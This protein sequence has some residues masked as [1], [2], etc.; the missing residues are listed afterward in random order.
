MGGLCRPLVALL[1]ALAVCVSAEPHQCNKLRE[2]ISC[3]CEA[4]VFKG[5]VIENQVVINCR[6]IQLNAVP[7]ITGRSNET[8]YELTLVHNNIQT[9]PAGAF[10][11]LRIQ[12]LDLR[13]NRLTSFSN[14]SFQGL[15]NDLKELYIGAENGASVAPPTSSLT[16]LTALN[17]LHLEYFAFQQ[18]QVSLGVL[19]V[20]T[21]LTTLTLKN[22]Q[23]SFIAP[24]ALPVYLTTLTL[25]NQAL[26]SFPVDVIRTLDKLESL[27]VT[28]TLISGL[29]RDSL[30]KNTKLIYLDLSDNKIAT[31]QE[32]CFEGITASLQTLSLK[33]NPL[34]TVVSLNE[35]E[36]LT[37]L[38]NLYLS[39]IG[40][41]T[42]PAGANFLLGKPSLIV[43][44]LD[45]NALTTLGADI[46]DSLG[47]LEELNLAYNQFTSLDDSAF[48]GLSSLKTLDL[49][50]QSRSGQGLT[51]PT[52]LTTLPSL[53][54]LQLSK[55]ILDLTV[56]WSRIGLMD[57]LQFLL[58]DGTSLTTIP[59][60]ALKN[61]TSL[62]ELNLNNNGLTEITQ[63]MLA[64]LRNL[65][66]LAVNKNSITTVSNC[67]FYDFYFSSPLSLELF[68]NPLVCDCKLK[69]LLD[70][71]QKGQITLTNFETCSSPPDKSGQLL[72]DLDS[73]TLT[74]V[75][76]Q[77]ADTCLELYTT[78]P[79]PSLNLA[80]TITNVNTTSL[81]LS[82]SL[83]DVPV[84]SHFQV[85]HLN[86]ETSQSQPVLSN[87]INVGNRS[88]QVTGL[89][90]NTPYSVCVFAFLSSTNKEEAC[91]TIR[92]L[93]GDGS[94]EDLGGGDN[95]S[96]EVGIIVGTV[97]GVLI[98]LVIIAAILYLLC[99][100]KRHS[101]EIPAQPHVFK[102]SELPTMNANSRQFTKPP[103]KVGRA[104]DEN[105]KVTV[106]SDGQTGPASPRH[107]VGSYQ[108]LND[109]HPNPN[110]GLG[111]NYSNNVDTRPLPSAP[112]GSWTANDNGGLH[113][114][115]SYD[116][117]ENK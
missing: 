34:Q 9:I 42:L 24:N 28:N 52:S 113:P 89:K 112:Q 103:P 91:N 36:R 58:L 98:L 6:N 59:D 10:K 25:D 102:P 8:I 31:L 57:S 70:E 62:K 110:P 47:S 93:A 49:G 50:H 100:R 77:P 86:L 76:A 38:T 35:I 111:P 11:G 13:K 109:K 41:S 21:R 94:A 4:R 15:E 84:V 82:W 5:V 14:S 1:C 90:P 97:V 71:H 29:Y 67:A 116:E 63:V 117:I 40:L 101:K 105:I 20:L 80:L 69:W 22:N 43:L 85:Q 115:H 106:I 23:L 3:P 64:G 87:D 39:S 30:L 66:N 2:I 44:H 107:S 54:T 56:L 12:R 37:A 46:F 27:T 74:C 73:G 45:G 79:A 78:T 53:Q 48:S 61:L 114:S 65:K 81:T 7:Q 95:S 26:T 88:F 51:L 104:L 60:Y 19:N 83:S 96:P 68:G 55:T 18:N 99:L 92:T 72:G 32:S 108:F 33:K 16:P 75:P 17:T